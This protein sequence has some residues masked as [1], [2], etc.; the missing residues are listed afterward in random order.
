MNGE[1][2]LYMEQDGSNTMEIYDDRFHRQLFSQLDI[3]KYIYISKN[4]HIQYVQTKCRN[5]LNYLHYL[6]QELSIS[7]NNRFFYIL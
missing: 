3:H 6:V 5:I 2:L 7:Q 4:E 1:L